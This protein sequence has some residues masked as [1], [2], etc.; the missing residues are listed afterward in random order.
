MTLVVKKVWGSIYEI[1]AVT[2]S[3]MSMQKHYNSSE[4]SIFVIPT[5]VKI[6]RMSEYERNTCSKLYCQFIEYSFAENPLLVPYI[7]YYRPEAVLRRCKIHASNIRPS[8]MY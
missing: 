8:N 1:I 5:F 6:P 2:R 3:I 7:V 4:L